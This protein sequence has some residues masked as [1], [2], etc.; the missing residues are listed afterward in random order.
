MSNS[1]YQLSHSINSNSCVLQG[2][3][4]DTEVAKKPFDF[5]LVRVP[6]VKKAILVLVLGGAKVK[7]MHLRQR[8]CELKS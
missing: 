1:S 7:C 6:M 3:K 2:A 4:V 8:E 5:R